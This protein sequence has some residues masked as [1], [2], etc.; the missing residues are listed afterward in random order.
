MKSSKTRV[1]WLLLVATFFLTLSSFG[2]T[3]SLSGKVVDSSGKALEGVSVLVKGH[4]KATATDATGAF[5]L[6]IPAGRATLVFSAVGYAPKEVVITAEQHTVTI[7]LNRSADAMQ[8]VIIVGYMQQSRKNVT[9]AVS[10]LDMAEMKDVTS[11]NPVLAL[12]GK[13][14]GVS[15]PVSSGQ[16]GASPVNII[17]R[18]GTRL[19][20]YGTGIGNSGGNAI[21]S[22][23]ATSPL[24][25]VDGVFRPMADVNPYNIES[26][27]VMKDAAAT[28]IYGSQ[29][30][31]GVIVIKTKSGKYN[32]RMTLTMNHRTTWETASR[33]LNYMNAEQYLRLARTTVFNTHDALPKDN[34]LNQGGFSAGTKVYTAKGQYGHDFYLTALY[35]NIVAV[36]GQDYVNNLLK[37]GW[38]TMDDPIKPGTTLLYADN[39]YQDLLWNTGLTN[40]ENISI[41][42]GSDKASYFLSANYINQAGT[43]VGTNYKRYDVLGNFSYKPSENFRLDVMTNYQNILPNYVAGFVNELIR[44]TRITPLVRIFKDNGD[45]SLGELWSTVNRF[46]TLKYDQTRV[47]TERFVNR[48]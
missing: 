17:I 4:K 45:P 8:D 23:N 34:M 16:P 32:K 2:Q 38:K 39:H 21:G 33:S 27:Q 36:E 25:I 35:D 18:G 3:I 5:N 15:V 42:G 24:V 22:S 41:D 29:G 14:P 47:S 19:N 7:A 30:A 46:H 6:T 48:I 12:Q 40:N 28:A 1:R 11:P 20:V 43:F 10:R 9:A 26:L 31:N 37:K 44:G 13:L